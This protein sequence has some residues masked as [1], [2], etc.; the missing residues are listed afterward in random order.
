M[1]VLFLGDS[2]PRQGGHNQA[3]GES[4]ASWIP[5]TPDSTINI[6]VS[7]LTGNGFLNTG[8]DE[9]G[10]WCQLSSDTDN[11]MVPVFFRGLLSGGITTENNINYSEAG[12]T[13]NSC[14]PRVNQLLAEDPSVQFDAIVINLGINT[15]ASPATV[16]TYEPQFDALMSALRAA[17]P[18]AFILHAA[19]CT[20]KGDQT[21][22]T[23]TATYEARVDE[24]NDFIKSK[25]LESS[26]LFYS[27]T[28][29]AI[30]GHTITADRWQEDNNTTPNIHPNSNGSGNYIAPQLIDDF[31]YVKYLW[32]NNVGIFGLDGTSAIPTASNAALNGANTMA[33]YDAEILHSLNYTGLGT[34]KIVRA[35][36]IVTGNL[37]G[38]V[39]PMTAYI[40][41]ADSSGG[42]NFNPVGELL[43]STSDATNIPFPLP[44]EDIYT[45]EFPTPYEPALGEEI[46]GSVGI[47]TGS[48][49]IRIGRTGA[50]DGYSYRS[51]TAG[52]AT[53]V[54]GNDSN[55]VYYIW[56]ETEPKTE[57]ALTAPWNVTGDGLTANEFLIQT[58]ETALGTPDS[59][60]Q[61][62]ELE[63]DFD[64]L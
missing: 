30:G 13:W 50:N 1:K 61:Y 12:G 34:E 37:G 64:D 18:N 44:A 11:G 33:T 4:G 41:G 5:T 26:Y 31:I 17:W 15:A 58:W 2:Y 20:L 57:T 55:H 47:P 14:L 46:I 49:N 23:P 38:V 56:F 54:Q 52:E 27:D 24:I 32:E 51:S 60:R 53:W 35:H 10:P 62:N 16:A 43:L 45:F 63:K 25:V 19:S 9:A 3:T 40:Y 59:G 29:T 22:Y 28:F 21:T 8:T 7:A 6:A 39:A 42:V 36:V 48:E